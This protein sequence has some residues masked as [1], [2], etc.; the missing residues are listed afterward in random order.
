M[1]KLVYIQLFTIA[2]TMRFFKNN[3]FSQFFIYKGCKYPAHFFHIEA[4]DYLHPP[5]NTLP[6]PQHATH[7]YYV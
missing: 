6:W 5:R 7:I 4:V 1:L 3:D 2:D